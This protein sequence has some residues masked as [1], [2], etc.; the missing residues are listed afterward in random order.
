M[1]MGFLSGFL[2]LGASV[3]AGE[4]DAAPQVQLTVK[5]LKANAHMQED[6]SLGQASLIAKVTIRNKSSEMV[7]GSVSAFEFTLLDGDGHPVGFAF[8]LVPPKLADARPISPGEQAVYHV[9]L[10][11]GGAAVNPGVDYVLRCEGVDGS[12]QSKVSFESYK[13]R[14]PVSAN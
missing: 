2:L 11:I 5:P 10:V 13:P 3:M 12:A 6:L 1:K 7:V 9:P 4:P 14:S 8:A